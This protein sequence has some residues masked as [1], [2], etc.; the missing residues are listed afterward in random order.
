METIREYYESE[1]KSINIQHSLV[2]YSPKGIEIGHKILFKIHLLID[3]NSKFISVYSDENV[4]FFAL[5]KHLENENLIN[6]RA[7]KL[8]GQNDDT[9]MIFDDTSVEDLTFTK[10]IIIYVNQLLAD[11][12]KKTLVSSGQKVGVILD[13]RDIGYLENTLKKDGLISPKGQPKSEDE[14]ISRTPSA[15]VIR[16]LRQEVGFLCPVDGCQNPFLTWHHFDPPWHEKEHHNPNGMLALCRTHHDQADNGAFTKEQLTRL[17]EPK[18]NIIH[19]KFNWL[20]NKILVNVGG[21]Y[22]YDVTDAISIDGE[23]W[24]WF[25]RDPQN[26]LLLNFSMPSTDSKP[27][28]FVKQNVWYELGQAE[29][30]TCPPHGRLIKAKYTNGD[31][32]K[33]EYTEIKSGSDLLKKYPKAPTSVTGIESPE[34]EEMRAQGKFIPYQKCQIEYPV[35]VVEISVKLKDGGLRITPSEFKGFNIKNCLLINAPLNIKTNR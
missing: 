12:Q 22:H 11:E 30:I 18:K 26:N 10:K 17:K 31:T 9:E 28:S 19:A 23:R 3:S 27:R 15:K 32:F 33:V 29:D 7:L 13:I 34:F 16:T 4:N 25:D 6:C 35:T 5:L 20:R 1:N 24:I 2:L 21:N 14:K 8:M